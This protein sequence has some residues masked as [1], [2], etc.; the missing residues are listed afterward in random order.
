M[1]NFASFEWPEEVARRRDGLERTGGHWLWWK[2][3]KVQ[4]IGGF[5]S[6]RSSARGFRGVSGVAKPPLPPPV[7]FRRRAGGQGKRKVPRFAGPAG[8]ERSERRPRE[9]P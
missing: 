2:N 9:W 1:Q 8:S 7:E 6:T 5:F 4:S 3:S